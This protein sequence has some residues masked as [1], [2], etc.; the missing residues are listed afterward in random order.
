MWGFEG[1]QVGGALVAARTIFAGGIVPELIGG[2]F[3]K[4][5]SFGG[6]DLGIEEFHFDGVVNAFDVG[7]GVGAG[8]GIEAMLGLVFLLD[9][10]MEAAG[11]VMDGGPVEF[12]SQIGGEN[13]L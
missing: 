10:E 12:D 13:G 11:L 7:I 8:R 6:K 3:G 2:G 1:E 4:E 5:I 9:G